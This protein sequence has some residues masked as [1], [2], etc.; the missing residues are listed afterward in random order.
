MS[1]G[2]LLESEASRGQK[3]VPLFTPASVKA[4]EKDTAPEL[5]AALTAEVT[6]TERIPAA[7]T[8]PL[9]AVPMLLGRV[10][11]PD[12]PGTVVP[13]R[14]AS[15]QPM[16]VLLMAWPLPVIPST[17]PLFSQSAKTLKNSIFV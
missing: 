15:V 12:S 7:E 6:E 2:L 17:S 10:G 4:M 5:R 1:L 3:L 8:V 9:P 11:Q 14:V 16:A 13:L